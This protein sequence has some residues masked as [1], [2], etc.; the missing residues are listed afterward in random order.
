MKCF[1]KRS[2]LALTLAALLLCGCNAQKTRFSSEEAKELLVVLDE[3]QMREE[4]GLILAST[5]KTMILHGSLSHVIAVGQYNEG[6]F[7]AK[8]YYA[9]SEDGIRYYYDARSDAWLELGFG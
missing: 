5:G 8:Y 7:E 1:N 3:I 4:E 2:L 9:A 6:R